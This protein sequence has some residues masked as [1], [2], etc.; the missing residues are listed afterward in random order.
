MYYLANMGVKRKPDELSVEKNSDNVNSNEN[1]DPATHMNIDATNTNNNIN[2]FTTSEEAN[3]AKRPRLDSNDNDHD[4]NNGNNA[5]NGNNNN[6]K[7]NQTN[8]LIQS[9]S[10][11]PL[12]DANQSQNDTEMNINTTL[13]IQQQS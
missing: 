3:N 4:N 11:T 2:D 10:S 6:N 9:P 7:N 13:P 5:I 1:I 12:I 8:D